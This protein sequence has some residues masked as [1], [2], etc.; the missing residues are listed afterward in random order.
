MAGGETAESEVP[1]NLVFRFAQFSFFAVFNCEHIPTGTLWHAALCSFNESFV[2]VA[3]SPE[4]PT[5][6]PTRFVVQ[7][8]GFEANA[9]GGDYFGE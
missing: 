6:G 2:F 7:V 1:Y 8:K 4:G 5:V 3:A 9:E